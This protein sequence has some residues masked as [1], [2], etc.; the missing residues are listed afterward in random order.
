MSLASLR[1]LLVALLAG[2]TIIS[3]L[4]PALQAQETAEA[5]SESSSEPE[6][7]T[8]G[9]MAP[10]IDIEHWM[11]D[12][13]ESF[14]PI[15]NFEPGQVYV[16]EFWATWCGPCVASMPHLSELQKEY[17]DQGVTIISVSDESL[18]KVTSFLER[19]V[20]GGKKNEDDE[21]QTYGQL[22][23]NYLL[24]TDPDGSVNTDYMRA[25]GQNGIPCA[26]V[27]GKSGH[28]E[29]I[30]HP[31]RMD[32]VLKQVVADEWDREAFGK[33]FIARQKVDAGMQQ[34]MRLMRGGNQDEAIEL[35][36]KLAADAPEDLKVR[37]EGF[38]KRMKLQA[39]YQEFQGLVA[40][41]QAAAAEQL[42]KML[43]TFG[44]EPNLVNAF[45]WAIAQHGDQGNEVSSD[46]LTAG[47]KAIE[48]VLDEENPD[49]SFLDTLSHLAHHQGDLDRAIELSETASAA[50]SGDLKRAIDL[51]LK[52]LKEEK[53]APAQSEEEEETAEEEE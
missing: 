37:I 10:G 48:A 6:M 50:A 25:A 18:E 16:M 5:A 45:V 32:P 51:Y 24:T 1:S 29:W 20:R 31:M 43:E 8:I 15:T 40:N 35:L 53:E 22:T 39:A 12:E 46:L 49:P 41:D 14:E 11:Q 19:E 3:P 38:I 27:V 44:N 36:T 34:A 2:G 4:A 26:F 47:S 13:D 17:A 30:G 28:I 33:E 7:L 23:S 9:S 42:P 52:R 21:P